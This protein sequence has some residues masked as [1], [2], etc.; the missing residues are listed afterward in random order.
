MLRAQRQIDGA[1]RG[2]SCCRIRAPA[3]YTK[4][5]FL[6]SYFLLDRRIR[7]YRIPD[8][9]EL[10][11]SPGIRQTESLPLEFDPEPATLS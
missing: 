7:N 3:A 6:A 2:V 11:Y 1:G 10:V 8:G 9:T 4:T 5:L